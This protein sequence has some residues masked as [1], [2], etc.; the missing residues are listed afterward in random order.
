MAD[1]ADFLVEMAE[2][3]D[4]LTHLKDL[5]ELPEPAERRHRPRR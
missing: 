4:E 1:V 2:W 3:A 5:D